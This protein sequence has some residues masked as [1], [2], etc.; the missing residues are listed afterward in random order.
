MDMSKSPGQ[1]VS[2]DVA[3]KYL[4][5]PPVYQLRSQYRFCLSVSAPHTISLPH[6]F[7]TGSVGVEFPGAATKL[8]GMDKDGNGEVCCIH[9]LDVSRCT[10]N[11]DNVEDDVTFWLWI[12]MGGRHVFMDGC[13]WL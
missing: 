8:D 9:A 13:C 5:A 6:K 12:C 2:R 10:K 11:P 1:S 4:F 3:L 7:H